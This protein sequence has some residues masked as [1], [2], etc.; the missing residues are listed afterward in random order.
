MYLHH[1]VPTININIDKG[2]IPDKP[3]YNITIKGVTFAYPSRPDTMVRMLIV[4]EI[5]SITITS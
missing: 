4:E 5:S 1:Q 3:S 2:I